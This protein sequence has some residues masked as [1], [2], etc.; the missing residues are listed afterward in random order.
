M[1]YCP[2]D[3][4]SLPEETDFKYETRTINK[5]FINNDLQWTNPRSRNSGVRSRPQDCHDLIV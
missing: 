1:S 2:S 3:P 4:S 5:I